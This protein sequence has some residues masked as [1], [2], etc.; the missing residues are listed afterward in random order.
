MVFGL[1]K[2]CAPTSR[3]VLPPATSMATWSSWG[4][5]SSLVAGPR[6]RTRSPVARSSLRARSAHGTA[7]RR[8]KTPS[9]RFSCSRASIRRP[10]RRS[11]SPYASR[12]R[13]VA[14]MFSSRAWSSS[15][16]SNSR[17]YEPSTA[18]SPRQ[19]RATACGNA[20]PMRSAS[21]AKGASSS[22]APSVSPAHERL[23][24]LR[25]GCVR[26]RVAQ[27]RRIAERAAKALEGRRLDNPDPELEQDERAQQVVAPAEVDAVGEHPRLLHIA[28]ALLRASLRSVEPRERA[29]RLELL[30]HLAGDARAVERFR[31]RRARRAPLAGDQLRPREETSSERERGDRRVFARP[32]GGRRGVRRHR[33]DVAEP[34]RGQSRPGQIPRVARQQLVLCDRLGRTAQERQAVF[35]PPIHQQ[36]GAARKRRQEVLVGLISVANLEQAL[37]Q[38]DRACYLP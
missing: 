18:S 32:P 38:H 21:S 12:V 33:R 29:E 22:V 35:G 26:R 23:D 31:E 5:S 7:S 13:A 16:R 19:R 20:W 6:A 10:L 36:D 9:A 25:R 34:E 37:A 28:P 8:S 14:N 2:S 11:R 27:E 24:E 30:V 4:V 3:F 15:E 17:S 1:R